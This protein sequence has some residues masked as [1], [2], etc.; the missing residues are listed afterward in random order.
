[1][2]LDDARYAVL[3][4][5]NRNTGASNDELVLLDERTQEKPYG[6]VFFFNTRRFVETRNFVFALGG[7]GPVV[8]ERETGRITLLGSARPP[9]KEIAEFERQSGLQRPQDPG[10]D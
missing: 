2:T 1:M 5:L 8:V 6:W 10:H 4:L 7:N 9:E 3:A